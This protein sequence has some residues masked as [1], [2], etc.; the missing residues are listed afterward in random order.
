MEDERSE[1]T[2]YRDHMDFRHHI[3]LLTWS[4]KLLRVLGLFGKGKIRPAIIEVIN[5]TA[6]SLF[7]DRLYVSCVVGQ[8]K[9]FFSSFLGITFPR[10]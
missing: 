5:F 8:G 6:P 7:L 4:P 1:E 2:S 3:S 9:S 10:Q